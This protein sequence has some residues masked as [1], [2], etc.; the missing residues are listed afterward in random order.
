MQRPAPVARGTGQRV[1][2][3]FACPKCIAI[4]VEKTKLPA[5]LATR[6]TRSKAAKARRSPI[7]A[8]KEPTPPSESAGPLPI[9]GTPED[10]EA[11]VALDFY[12]EGLYR[13][14]VPTVKRLNRI[15]LSTYMIALQRAVALMTADPENKEAVACGIRLVFL[16]NMLCLTYTSPKE[17][18]TVQQR[19]QRFVNGEW[20][21]L[22]K[23]SV[24]KVKERRRSRRQ[25]PIDIMKTQKHLAE[26]HLRRGEYSKGLRL[27]LSHGKVEE[28]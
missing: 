12:E 8:N 7:R 25:Q 14:D 4:A 17:R 27:S 2:G 11:L 18:K 5:R 10:R 15:G 1:K 19:L 26:Q 3:D 22:Y 24:E 9:T 13:P 21:A 20:H 6:S 23:E 16:L 28:C